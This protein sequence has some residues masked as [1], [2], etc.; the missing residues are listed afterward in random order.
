[1]RRILGTLVLALA[2]AVPLAGTAGAAEAVPQK[3][4]KRGTF[5]TWEVVG[6][7]GK[8]RAVCVDERPLAAGANYGAGTAYFPRCPRGTKAHLVNVEG[9]DLAAA[10]C[11]RK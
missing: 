3:V 11:K 1:M 4:C 10:R 2:L 5:A 7:R 6:K 8:L 9:T